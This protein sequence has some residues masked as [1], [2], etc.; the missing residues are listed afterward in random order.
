MK[1]FPFG[2]REDREM[3]MS[4]ANFGASRISIIKVEKGNTDGGCN[5][6]GVQVQFKENIHYKASRPKADY[7]QRLFKKQGWNVSLEPRDDSPMTFICLSRE[8]T[9]LSTAEVIKILE[10]DKDNLELPEAWIPKT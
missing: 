1:I 9:E 8:G 10:S 6:S 3:T 7:L 5:P 4:D 2:S